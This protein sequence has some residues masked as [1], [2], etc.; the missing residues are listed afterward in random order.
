MEQG[1]VAGVRYRF[2]EACLGKGEA[3]RCGVVLAQGRAGEAGAEALLCRRLAEERCSLLSLELL[4][5]AETGGRWTLAD[6]QKRA[7]P[8]WRSLDEAMQK[9][10]PKRA[11]VALMGFSYGFALLLLALAAL[12]GQD[13]ALAKRLLGRVK[14]VIGIGPA[15]ALAP[16]ASPLAF[17]SRGAQRAGQPLAAAPLEAIETHP[18]FFKG[19]LGRQAAQ[20]LMPSGRAALAALPKVKPPF[21]L[22]FGSQGL[23]QPPRAEALGAREDIDIRVFKGA[24]DGLFS[25]D[26][27]LSG[28]TLEAALGAIDKLMAGAK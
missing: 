12:D 20:K 3:V 17:L 23:A 15:L 4:Q 27:C 22:L 25:G 28:R 7:L 6:Y 5:G 24:G 14:L 9:H 2:R 18:K 16:P 13:K 10:F 1:E 19:S 26:N 11:P 21:L 8:V